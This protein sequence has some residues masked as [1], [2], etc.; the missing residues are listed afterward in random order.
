MTGL[1]ASDVACAWSAVAHGVFAAL[2]TRR[3]VHGRGLDALLTAPHARAARAPS[4]ADAARAH[5]STAVAFAAL[6]LLAR[7]PGWRNT[8]LYRA[9]AECLVLRG[10]GMPAVLRVGV[11]RAAGPVAA[12]AWT[13]CAGHRCQSA[14]GSEGNA[15]APLRRTVAHAAEG[16]VA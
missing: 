7:L 1:R 4:A 9:V 5:Q 3:V 10:R 15:Y 11:A 14:T 6:R 2:L 13:E 16:A 12:H 8:C